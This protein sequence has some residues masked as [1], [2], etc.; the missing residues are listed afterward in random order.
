MRQKCT[1]YALVFSSHMLTDRTGGGTIIFSESTELHAPGD[2]RSKIAV[3]EVET[4]TARSAAVRSPERT[5][6]L[7]R[8]RV[9]SKQSACQPDTN[10]PS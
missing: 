7:E 4:R 6:E 1:C 10:E 3:P 9:N 5:L 8:G 2:T